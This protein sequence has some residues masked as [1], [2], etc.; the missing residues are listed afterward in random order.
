[1]LPTLSTN[2]SEDESFE[3]IKKRAIFIHVDVPGQGDEESDLPNDFHFPTMQN[4][5][6]DLVTILDQLR[7]KYC[8]GL[9]DGAGANI[10]V[11][12]GMMHVSRCLGKLFEKYNLFT[13]LVTL[14]HF[15]LTYSSR[16]YP[17]ESNH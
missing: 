7:I 15:P 12:F 4:L 13:M 16:S 8:V 6:E 3:E 11:R 14:A 2:I 10:I 1:M 9:G 5:G 17:L